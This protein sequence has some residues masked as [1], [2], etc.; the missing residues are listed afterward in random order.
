MVTAKSTFDMIRVD[1]MKWAV[2]LKLSDPQVGL[3]M[4]INIFVKCYQFLC[5]A[6]SLHKNDSFEEL[7]LP[8][9]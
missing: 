1:N 8:T 6:I 5:A 4:K 7:R 3:L 2:A 9:Q